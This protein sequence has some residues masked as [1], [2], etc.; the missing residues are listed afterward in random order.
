MKLAFPF[1][2]GKRIQQDYASGISIFRSRGSYL[3]IPGTP[4]TSWRRTTTESCMLNRYKREAQNQI[5]DAVLIDTLT[6]PL[7]MFSALEF[8][9]RKKYKTHVCC[10]SLTS[11]LSTLSSNLLPQLINPSGDLNG[12]P[13]TIVDVR[14]QFPADEAGDAVGKPDISESIITLLVQVEETPMTETHVD[15]AITINV[16]SVAE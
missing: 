4:G 12:F 15:F 14:F 3:N 13:S 11:S 16:R 2:Q 5:T 9:L 8:G 10:A 6:D 1:Q 7:T